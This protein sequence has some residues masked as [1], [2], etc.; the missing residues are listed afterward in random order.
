MSDSAR[1]ER[2][3]IADR[4]NAREPVFGEIDAE[5]VLDV[6]D[7]LEGRDR[8]EPD[9]GHAAVERLGVDRDLGRSHRFD[10]FADELQDVDIIGLH[11]DPPSRSIRRSSYC[12]SVWYPFSNM[13]THVR[14]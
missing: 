14:R 11:G 2:D 3:E 10:G 13:R 7:H 4:A 8:V 6:P 1:D 9:V 5:A 12:P